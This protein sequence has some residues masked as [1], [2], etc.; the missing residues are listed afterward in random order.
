MEVTTP[1]IASRNWASRFFVD[2]YERIEAEY[3]HT[4]KILCLV[5]H[6]VRMWNVGRDTSTWGL[7]PPQVGPVFFP[8][9]NPISNLRPIKT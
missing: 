9:N 3:I 1:I 6:A 8:P 5:I 7:L 4:A 2:L